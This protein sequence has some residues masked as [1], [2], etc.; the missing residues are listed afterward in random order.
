MGRPR[1]LSLKDKRKIK[2]EVIK[3]KRGRYTYQSNKSHK[4]NKINVKISE[5]TRK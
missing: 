5:T 2:K 3:N 4:R 1:E